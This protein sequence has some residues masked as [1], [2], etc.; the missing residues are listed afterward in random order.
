MGRVITVLIVLL[1]ALSLGVG[2]S[3][4]VG[5]AEG[6]AFVWELRL[7]RSLLAA[8]AGAGLGVAGVITQGLFRNPLAGP[9][10]LG[11]TAGA[12]LGGQLAMLGHAVIAA[13]LP[14]LPAEALLPAGCVL[15][16]G[17]ALAL[18]LVLTQRSRGLL[19]VLL[20]GF[21]LATL[22]A[23]LGALVTSLAQQSWELGRAMVVFTLGSLDGKGVLHVAV[24]APLIAIGSA[25]A[26]TWHRE[27]DLLLGGEEEAASLGVDV[28]RARRWLLAWV[29][30]LTAA[31]VAVG[32]GVAFVG[33]V[34]PHLLRPF[35][36]VSHRRLLPLAVLA[37]AA[38]LVWCDI[39]AR[40]VP[41]VGS[42]PLGVVTGLLGIPAFVVILRRDQREAFT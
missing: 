16:A 34:V 5:P 1:L 42:V 40:A 9:S 26:W 6:S 2:V 33:L 27:L 24:A 30:V 10:V 23:S 14:W 38:W 13:A 15:G 28:T 36:G 25:M 29:A 8:L 12:A 39:I 11:T 31:A 17:G 18:L 22:F 37:G 32:G 7:V 35:A 19:A 41:A 20:V 4:L 21:L 3:L